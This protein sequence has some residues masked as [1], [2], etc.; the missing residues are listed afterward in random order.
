M[1]RKLMALLL[2]GVVITSAPA[3]PKDRTIH[4][5][6]EFDGVAVQNGRLRKMAHPE[7]GGEGQAAAAGSSRWRLRRTPRGT[8]IYLAEGAWG[9]WYLNYDHRGKDRRVALVPEPGPGCYWRWTEGPW[10]KNKGF[11]PSG[12]GGPEYTIACRARPANGP[13]KGW[14]LAADRAGVVLARSPSAELRFMAGGGE[15]EPR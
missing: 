13:F 5:P 7:P 6:V 2:G 4:Q 10:E 8:L 15:R 12:P 1:L 14:S 9:G 3:G 11:G